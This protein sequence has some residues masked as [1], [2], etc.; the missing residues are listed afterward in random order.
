DGVV[1]VA[2]QRVGDQLLDRLLV[3]DEQYPSSS[4][5]AHGQSVIALRS[6]A[7]RLRS[8]V[9]A[10]RCSGA[11][12]RESADAGREAERQ[13]ASKQL[14]DGRSSPLPARV[15][16]RARRARRAAVLARGATRSR[17]LADRAGYVRADG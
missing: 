2:T 4:L 10:A 1:A 14:R 13:G 6:R 15:H 7:C 17:A 16:S 8:S 9:L 3:V 12:L 11:S 5:R